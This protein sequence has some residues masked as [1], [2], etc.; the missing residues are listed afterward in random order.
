MRWGPAPHVGGEGMCW[1]WGALRAIIA[2]LFA[3]FVALSHRAWQCC[4]EDGCNPADKNLTGNQLCP[5]WTVTAAEVH[6]DPEGVP[7]WK[8]QGEPELT[9][10]NLVICYLGLSNTSSSTSHFFR[11]PSSPKQRNVSILMSGQEMTALGRSPLEP[12]TDARNPEPRREAASSLRL[13][14]PVCGPS[15]EGQLAWEL[16][17]SESEGGC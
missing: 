7:G 5:P 13:S 2:V 17:D 11:V 3:G 15:T 10:G 14:G 4:L 12:W 9:W 8:D 1:A 16:R 6:Q